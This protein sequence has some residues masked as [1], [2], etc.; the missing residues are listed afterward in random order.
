MD[1]GANRRAE[2]VELGLHSSGEAPDCCQAL[3]GCLQATLVRIVVVVPRPKDYL[4]L[5]VLSSKPV[6]PVEDRINVGAGID[7]HIAITIVA[8]GLG[9]VDEKARDSFNEAKIEPLL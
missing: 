3:E 2:S 8:Y 7:Y 5:R 4:H 9:P 6:E 1:N